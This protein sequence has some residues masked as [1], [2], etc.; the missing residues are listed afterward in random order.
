[1]NLRTWKD[2]KSAKLFNSIL[3]IPQI[4]TSLLWSGFLAVLVTAVMFTT[5]TESMLQMCGATAGYGAVC[6]ASI[7]LTAAIML[8]GVT[9]LLFLGISLGLMSSDIVMLW[10]QNNEKQPPRKK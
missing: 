7:L 2:I 9:T 4:R 3:R 1:M 8:A 5:S 6:Y 10:R